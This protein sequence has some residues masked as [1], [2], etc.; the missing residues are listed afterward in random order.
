MRAMLPLMRE[1][2][3]LAIYVGTALIAAGVGHVLG[4]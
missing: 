1:L 3:S 2:L 4:G